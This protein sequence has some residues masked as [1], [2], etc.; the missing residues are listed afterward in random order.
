MSAFDK[1][2]E[3]LLQE[4]MPDMPKSMQMDFFNTLRVQSSSHIE[5]AMVAHIIKFL[6]T[7][8]MEYKIDHLGNIL[9]TKGRCDGG[10]TFYPCIASHMDTVHSIYHDFSLKIKRKGKHQVALA[11]SHKKQVGIGG[12]DK[13][14]VYACMHMLKKFDNIKAV[15]FTQ[16]ESGLIGSSGVDH[17]WF[18]D[19]GY[20][21]QLDRWGRGDFINKTYS[22]STVSN[23]FMEKVDDILFH[24]GYAETTGLITDSINMHGDNIGVSCVNVSCGYYQHHT[25]QEIVNLNHYYNSLLFTEDIIKLLGEAEYKSYPSKRYNSYY[26]DAYDWDSWGGG[27]NDYGD[28]IYD[29]ETKTWITPDEYQ[30]R[31]AKIDMEA[32]VYALEE[33]DYFSLYDVDNVWTLYNTYNEYITDEKYECNFQDFEAALYEYVDWDKYI[34]SIEEG[35]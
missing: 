22:G 6:H 14:G 17:K 26:D 3:Q 13:C 24:Y 5:H 9:V 18:A 33:L 35:E 29:K 27:V 10:E 30:Q 20:I 16:E 11:H 34:D 23:E 28:W 15:F 7:N 1:Q 4:P 8:D 19:V 21:I 12:D 25:N 32:L 2:S 31:N